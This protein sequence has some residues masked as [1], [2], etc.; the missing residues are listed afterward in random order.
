[1]NIKGIQ[2]LSGAEKD[3][4]DGREFYDKQDENVGDYFWHSLLSDIESFVFL[5]GIHKKS[6][7]VSSN[8]IEAV[9]ICNLL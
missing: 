3:L 7:W 9:S 4:D 1:M 6:I 8:V 5:Q 2:I